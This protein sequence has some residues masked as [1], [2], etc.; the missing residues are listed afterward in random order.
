[1]LADKPHP[2]VAI[3]FR[4]AGKTR[5]K[6]EGFR[7]VDL[8]DRLFGHCQTG[9]DVHNSGCRADRHGFVMPVELVFFHHRFTAFFAFA[10]ATTT[11]PHCFSTQ[12]LRFTSFFSCANVCSPIFDTSNRAHARPAALAAARLTRSFCAASR[13]S[14]E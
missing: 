10:S 8:E 5:P 12:P 14:C 3:Q 7:F 1:M 6:T 9:I 2:E 13:S 11:G 4:S